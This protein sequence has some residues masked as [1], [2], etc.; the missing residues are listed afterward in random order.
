M[1]IL[2]EDNR[3]INRTYGSV[4]DE[5]GGVVEVIDKVNFR[6][7]HRLTILSQVT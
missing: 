6:D 1:V 4:T 7:V 3:I 2:S 5:K